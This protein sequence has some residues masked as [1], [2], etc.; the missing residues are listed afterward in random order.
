MGT[1]PLNI[2]ETILDERFG[3]FTSTHNEDSPDGDWFLACEIRLPFSPINWR[4][5]TRRIRAIRVE[6][7][8]H[9]TARE[10]RSPGSGASLDVPESSMPAKTLL[11]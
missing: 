4:L 11:P 7:E 6:S 1:Y 2:S 8:L 9:L 3:L 10:S 5:R